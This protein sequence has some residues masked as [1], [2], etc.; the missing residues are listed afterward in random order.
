M[1]SDRWRRLPLAWLAGLGLAFAAGSAWSTAR[2][3]PPTTPALEPHAGE[4]SPDTCRAALVMTA[5]A[6]ASAAPLP[7]AVASG[8]A[9]A[10][11]ADS[12]E[13]GEA[14][15]VDEAVA[16]TTF[17]AAAAAA[18]EADTADPVG[19]RRGED[20]IGALVKARAGAFALE[21]ANCRSHTCVA[22]LHALA[23]DGSSG[24]LEDLVA[25]LNA[26]FSDVS[27]DRQPSGALKIYLAR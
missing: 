22:Q 21:R 6:R 3:P 25:G 14:S 23:R 4:E 13:T 9:P 24:A 11:L 10:A 2:R 18:H 26:V 20:D 12:S 15:V 5:L 8:A 19:S 7:A 1:S 16:Q 27:V 17:F